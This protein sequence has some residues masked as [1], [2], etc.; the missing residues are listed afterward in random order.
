MS[1]AINLGAS[2]AVSAHLSASAWIVGQPIPHTPPERVMRIEADDR[3]YAI[4]AEDRTQRA[5]AD[6]RA[7]DVVPA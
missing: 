6:D 5:F 4:P 3:T 7:I 1:A 2:R